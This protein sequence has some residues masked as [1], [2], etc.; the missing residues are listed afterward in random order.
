MHLRSQRRATLLSLDEPT[1]AQ[2]SLRLTSREPTPEES[3]AQREVST[4]ISR[5]VAR[6]PNRLRKPYALHAVSGLP[7]AEV[8]DK[9]GLSVSATKSRIFRARCTLESRLFVSHGPVRCSA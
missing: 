2:I 5:A 8:A 6:L 3:T 9:L 1:Q 4:A 7:V